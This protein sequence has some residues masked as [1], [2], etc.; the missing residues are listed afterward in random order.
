MAGMF[1]ISAALSPALNIRNYSASRHNLFTGW[2]ANPVP[3][4]QFYQAARDFSGVGWNSADTRKHVTLVSP[5]HF[6][7]A[8]HFRPAVGSLIRFVNR[9]GQLK[10]HTIAAI[11]TIPNSEGNAT[12]ILVGELSAPIPESDAIT[13]Y[14]YLNLATEAAYSGR[15]LLVVGRESSVGVGTLTG[16]LNFGGDPLTSGTGINNTRA[17]SFNYNTLVGGGDDCHGEGGDS[18]GP[19]FATTTSGLA[20]VGIHTAIL[21][22]AGTITTIDSFIPHY[23]DEINAV[24]AG[25][26]YHLSEATP[27]ETALSLEVTDLADP[28]ATRGTAVFQ[29]ALENTGSNAANNLEVQYVLPVGATLEGVSGSGWVAQQDGG[30]ILCLRGGLAAGTPTTLTLSIVMPDT[31]GRTESLFGLSSDESDTVTATETTDVLLS[32]SVWAEDLADPTPSGD[33]D[34]NQVSNA[35]QFA[36]GG[37]P[38]SASLFS[39]AGDPLLPTA[40]S[41]TGGDGTL[42]V[43]YR[44][45][46]AAATLGI[47]Y[48]LQ[49]SASLAAG[50]WKLC[51]DSPSSPFPCSE[52]VESLDDSEFGMERVTAT[53]QS[54]GQPRLFARVGVNLVESPN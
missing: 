8:N 48:Q 38:A 19:S 30:T 11:H 22:A 16:I 12:D 6:V 21:N 5:K 24:L 33:D 27:A 41:G 20:I 25:A 51:D 32:Y 45:R 52:T 4:P 18:G 26:G 28:V 49:L 17:S 37:T 44:R 29:M 13:H 40:A 15:S 46:R 9:N 47:E 34:G 53:I 39:P 31:A 36:F 10:S 54:T 35:L 14:P 23:V 3:N 2:P 43:I 42:Q 1:L 7:C 50:D